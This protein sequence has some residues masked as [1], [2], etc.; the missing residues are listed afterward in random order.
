M[1]VIKR[2]VAESMERV[3]YLGCLNQNLELSEGRQGLLLAEHKLVK[4]H[5]VILYDVE[6]ILFVDEDALWEY[7]ELREFE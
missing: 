6:R 7:N 5:V 4:T 1:A 2:L 3:D